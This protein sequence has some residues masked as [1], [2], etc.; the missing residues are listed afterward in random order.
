MQKTINGVLFKKMLNVGFSSLEKNRDYV[1][2]LN[3]FPVP[4]GDT[5][6]NMTL[7]M[8]SVLKEIET[9]KSPELGIIAPAVARGGL[10]GARG[11]SGV[12]LSQIFKGMMAEMARPVDNQ[13]AGRMMRAVKTAVVGS[14][15]PHM[16]ARSTITTRDFSRAL[17]AGSK[18]AYSAVTVPK[19]GTILTVIRVM[20]EESVKISKAE[21]DFVAFFEKLLIVG[22]DILQKTPDMLPVLKKAGVVDSGGRGLLIIFGGFMHA[23]DPDVQ[24]SHSFETDGKIGGGFD[25]SGASL[26]DLGEIEFAYCTEF[27]IMNMHKTT[28]LASIDT[29]REKLVNMGDSVVCVGDLEMVKV[30]VHTNTPGEAITA[31]LM[32]GEMINLKIDNMLQQNRELRAS[33]DMDDKEMGMVVIAAGDG[34]VSLFKDLHVDFVIKGGQTMNPCAEEIAK[35]CDRVHAK[36]VFVFPNNKNIIL[37]AR[38][39]QDLCKKNLVI[40]PT[41]TINEGISACVVFD[42]S[43]SIE[44]NTEAFMA[45]AAAVQSGSVTYAVRNTKVAR[46]S[47]KEGEVL[48][49][50]TKN[51]IAKGTSIPDV[52]TKV[53][54]KLVTEES[55]SVTLFYGEGIKEKDANH[56]HDKLM[57]KYPNLDVSM[58][59]GGQP[60]YYYLISVE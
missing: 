34:M 10:K 28:T 55:S 22:E 48:G 23:L 16:G 50:D 13:V 51:V 12:I 43:A 57:A 60:V 11:N 9:I 46:F 42:E 40:I 2:S 26:D 32:L 4:D 19:E 14:D 30:H 6:T 7:T 3:V 45:A 24:V 33:R 31:A 27:N 20:A 36:T 54:E 25:E 39:A 15:N 47:I 35:A 53:V 1:D 38:H 49:L 8:K 56:L 58:I 5:G 17:I 59:N 37:A 21:S 52:T 41:K 44:E 29:L 18:T